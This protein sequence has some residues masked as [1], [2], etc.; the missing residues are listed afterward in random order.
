MPEEDRSYDLFT[1]AKKMP[2]AKRPGFL[3]KACAGDPKL[4]ADV[5][6]LLAADEQASSVLD[7]PAGPPQLGMGRLL[8]RAWSAEAEQALEDPGR[9]G[10]STS[11]AHRARS[12]FFWVAVAFGC[13]LLLF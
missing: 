5:E 1:A 7:T 2:P 12:G 3:K 9:P 11:W 6:S 8:G 10:R 4:R 13:L